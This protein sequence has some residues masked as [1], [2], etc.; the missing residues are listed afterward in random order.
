[1]SQLQRVI[2]SQGELVIDLEDGTDGPFLEQS[3]RFRGEFTIGRDA[4]L[5]VRVNGA[6]VAAFERDGTISGFDRA[7][8]FRMAGRVAANDV[9]DDAAAAQ[10]VI[11]DAQNYVTMQAGRAAVIV[12]P[13]GTMR[14][15]VPLTGEVD[16][17][18][19]VGY[20]QGSPKG[21]VVANTATTFV[22]GGS[23]IS[24]LATFVGSDVIRWSQPAGNRV[25]SGVFMRDFSIDGFSLPGTTNGIRLQTF[26]GGINR[27]NVSR[28]SGDGFIVEGTGSYNFPDDAFDVQLSEIKADSVGGNGVTFADGASSDCELRFSK[29]VGCG[30]H[31]I[32][33]LTPGQQIIGCH[34][35]LCTG[36]AVYSVAR[37]T[38]ISA[39]RI[40]DCQQGGVYLWT[41]ASGTTGQGGNFLI[42]GLV[43][44]DLGKAADN[45]Y[46]VVNWAP[47]V[48]SI[49]GEVLGVTVL[50]TQANRPRYGV[51][52]A[53]AHAI[54]TVI[55]PVTG[56]FV[57][58]AASA[59]GTGAVNTGAATTPR[60]F[61]ALA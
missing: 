7:G 54:S 40:S 25:L 10:A 8:V 6:E 59:F 43:V 30:G 16:N 34:V 60:N 50:T 17:V 2:R 61:H 35:Y 52:L 48:D 51:N 9:E 32:N 46:D 18:T 39:L 20:G 13:P 4:R 45:T 49:G 37:S 27:V 31:G 44:R 42:N 47:G 38:V 21:G 24:P 5:P 56:D 3:E 1:M 23:L 41:P 57:S 22:R 28:V 55:G 19:V 12:L 33:N 53:N 26:D 11:D 36:H 14:T 29:F 15:S 58:P